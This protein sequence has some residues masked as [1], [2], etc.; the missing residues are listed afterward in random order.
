MWPWEHLAVGYIAISVALGLSGRRVD[1]QVALLVLFG[2]QFPDLVD[3]PLAWSLEVL[4]SGTSLAHSVFVAIP[5][6]AA[7]VLVAHRRGSIHFG[8]AF[9]LAYL[10]HLP[11]D[12]LYETLTVGGPPSFDIIL[13]PLVPKPPGGD[14]AGLF[15]KTLYYLDRYKTF[16][17]Q[18]QAVRYLVLEL[19]LLV[20]ALALWI[21]DGRPGPRLFD[22]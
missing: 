8:V 3:K 9:G 18:P 10:L 21:R 15:S 20:S 14:T 11:S 5:L 16:L 19:L 17:T 6:T 22:R 13:W 7:V 2:S 4:P 1:D 12:A